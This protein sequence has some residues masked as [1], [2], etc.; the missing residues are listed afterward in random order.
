MKTA[1]R[2]ARP[3][4][5]SMTVALL[6]ACGG[7]GGGAGNSP[8][9]PPVDTTPPDTTLSAKPAALSNVATASFSFTASEAGSTF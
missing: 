4:F 7:G 8:P 9:P 5:L 2:P 1:N 3:A 6:A